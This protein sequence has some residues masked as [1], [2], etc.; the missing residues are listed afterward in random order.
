MLKLLKEE[1]VEQPI[2]K[3]EEMP[4]SAEV[5]EKAFVSSVD[6]LV[7]N[8]WD[9]ISN[10]NSL[11]ATFEYHYKEDNLEDIKTILA[12]VSDNATINIGMLTKLNQLISLNRDD[13]LKRGEQEAEELI[14]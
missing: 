8:A 10:A 7:Q 9:F 1:K 5:E 11:L 2:E 13:L 12:E 3:I 14:K 6:A 4:V